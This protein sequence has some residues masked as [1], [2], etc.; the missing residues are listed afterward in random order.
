MKSSGLTIHV[1]YNDV[2]DLTESASILKDLPRLIGM[3]MDLYEVLISGAYKAVAYEI[4]RDIITDLI[5]VKVLS[6]DE[7]LGIITKFNGL[8]R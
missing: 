8:F 6:F 1:F 4:I 3:E 7:K 2:E 5:L